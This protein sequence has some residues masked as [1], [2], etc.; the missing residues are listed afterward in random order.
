MIVRLN[1]RLQVTEKQKTEITSILFTFIKR[2]NKEDE[3]TLKK[4]STVEIVNRWLKYTEKPEWIKEKIDEDIEFLAGI[5]EF[6]NMYKNDIVSKEIN[7]YDIKYK[8]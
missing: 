5:C 8:M 6:V 7:E 4:H 3:E 1:E 2:I